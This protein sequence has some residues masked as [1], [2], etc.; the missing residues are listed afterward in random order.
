MSG[1]RGPRY[2]ALAVL[3][4][5]TA[6]HFITVYGNG[7]D[8]VLPT[9]RQVPFLA[10]RRGNASSPNGHG[11]VSLQVAAIGEEITLS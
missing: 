11:T 2:E 5:L 3:N 4:S 10:D 1:N 8:S 6:G 9:A 7:C